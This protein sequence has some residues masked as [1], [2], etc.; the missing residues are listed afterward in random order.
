MNKIVNNQ[1]RGMS[2]IHEISILCNINL[3]IDNLDY[4]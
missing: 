3:I 1:H 4:S 2:T